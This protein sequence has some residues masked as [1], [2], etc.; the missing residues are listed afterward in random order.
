[1]SLLKNSALANRLKNEAI[2]FLSKESVVLRHERMIKLSFVD[3]TPYIHEE[4]GF[5]DPDFPHV[6]SSI[7]ENE[8]PSEGIEWLPAEEVHPSP[9]YSELITNL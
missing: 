9:N 4:F 6:F 3:L 8:V 7:N 1:M 2:G 5:I